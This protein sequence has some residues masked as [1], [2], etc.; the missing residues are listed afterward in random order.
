[1]SDRLMPTLP[2]SETPEAI[3]ATITI[4]HP[5]AT[6]ST[7]IDVMIIGVRVMITVIHGTQWA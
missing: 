4:D 3:T 5:T 2:L 7:Q 6:T 1:M